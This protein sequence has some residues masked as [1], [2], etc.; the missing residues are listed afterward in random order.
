[1][2]RIRTV[3]P[4]FYRH[5]GLQDLEIG[6]PGA[7]PMLVYQGLWSQC[8]KNGAFQW[9]PRQLKLDILPFLPFEMADTLNILERAGYVKRYVVEGKEYGII[10]TF[11]TH[12]RFSGKETGGEGEKYPLPGCELQDTGKHEGSTGEAMG[13]ICERPVAQERERER[14]IGKDILS[15]KKPDAMPENS[16]TTEKQIKIPYTEIIQH[17]N[18]QTG[19]NFQA[20]RKGTQSHIK[21]RFSEGFT[22]ANFFSVIDRKTASWRGDPKMADYLRPETLFGPK[23][24]AYLNESGVTTSSSTNPMREF[25]AG[26]SLISADPKEL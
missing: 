24:E 23:F 3:K 6:N 11:T 22:L 5:E 10:P 15:G 8:D 25:R 7:Y 1:M 4:E 26:D 19:K 12:Q 16:K 20:N 17:L 21:A 13:K 18:Q 9:R 14:N 2:A